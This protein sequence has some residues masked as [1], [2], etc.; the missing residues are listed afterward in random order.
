MFK[1]Q[2]HIQDITY[3]HTGFVWL[4][5][6]LTQTRR[7]LLQK[8]ASGSSVCCSCYLHTT[9]TNRPR[10]GLGGGANDVRSFV[11]PYHSRP[12]YTNKKVT[13]NCQ[14]SNELSWLINKHPQQPLRPPAS[15]SWSLLGFWFT[16]NGCRWT[17]TYFVT[18]KKVGVYWDG[19]AEKVAVLSP[20]SDVVNLGCYRTSFSGSLS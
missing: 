7:A 17:H 20:T 6:L 10:P 11:R 14:P 1:S 8:S 15:A 16:S 12:T 19:S 9:A 3:T 5:L 4:K 13:L 18:S 2:T